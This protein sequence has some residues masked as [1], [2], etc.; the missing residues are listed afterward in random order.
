MPT[1]ASYRFDLNLIL[2]YESYSSFIEKGSK[3]FMNTERND[4]VIQYILIYFNYFILFHN[5]FMSLVEKNH[6]SINLSS[7][8]NLKLDNDIFK[9]TK[10]KTIF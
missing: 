8:I 6:C 10:Y 1:V 5:L 3:F 2:L 9:L 4:I 7:Q